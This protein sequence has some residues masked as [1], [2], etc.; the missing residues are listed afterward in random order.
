MGAH[1]LENGIETMQLTLTSFAFTG[2]GGI[3]E[4]YPSDGEVLTSRHRGRSQTR[5]QTATLTSFGLQSYSTSL[6]FG[7]PARK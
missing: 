3:P 7:K 1:R 6:T 4:K 2:R 5:G